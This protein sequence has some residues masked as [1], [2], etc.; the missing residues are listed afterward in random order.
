MDE[1]KTAHRNAFVQR[2]KQ[3]RERRN[4]TQEVIAAGLDL[5]QDAYKHYEIRSYLPYHLIHRFCLI[6]HVSVEWLVTGQEPSIQTIMPNDDDK[7]RM[8]K[9]RRQKFKAA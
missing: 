2:V 8:V 7:S 5:E 9:R 4:I 6:C 1:A 3:A